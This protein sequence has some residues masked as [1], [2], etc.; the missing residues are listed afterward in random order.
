[1]RSLTTCSVAAVGLV[2]F[3]HPVRAAAPKITEQATTTEQPE[4]Q[5][6]PPKTSQGHFI[7]LGLYGVGAMAFDPNRGTRAPTVG[8]GFS[9]RLGENV[10]PWLDLGV[11]FAYASTQGNPEDTLTFGR[12]GIQSQWYPSRN[13]FAQFGFGATSASGLDPE[14]LELTR[15]RYGAVFWTG[16]GTNI[17]ISNR[18][19]SGG[20][21]LT[22]VA[23]LEIAPGGMFTSTALWLG[24]EVS[25]WSGLSRNKLKL[26]TSEAYRGKR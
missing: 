13:W 3:Q 2:F 21:T 7:A 5:L 26:T 23:T 6:V 16:I 24:L 18:F 11:A 10:T 1:M 25:F 14:D 20:W 8:E 19:R 4:V 22:P 12:L 15:N 17:P 9:L